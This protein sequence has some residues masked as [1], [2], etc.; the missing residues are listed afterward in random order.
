MRPMEDSVNTM[1]EQLYSS[2]ANRKEAEK[3][4]ER[5]EFCKPSEPIKEKKYVRFDKKFNP[6]QKKD[7]RIDEALLLMS[8]SSRIIAQGSNLKEDILVK[9]REKMALS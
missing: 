7:S 3:S 2:N 5:E 8:Q 6:T 1:N 4:S 9:E